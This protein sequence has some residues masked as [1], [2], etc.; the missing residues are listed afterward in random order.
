[1][2]S[3]VLFVLFGEALMLLSGPHVQWA[4]IF[5]VVNFIYIPLFE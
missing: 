4:L 5:L 1:M 3:G 2:I